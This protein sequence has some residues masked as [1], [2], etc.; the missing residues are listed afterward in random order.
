MT[1][2]IKNIVAGYL[3]LKNRR[4]FEEIRDYR[5]TTIEPEP[6]ARPELG[7]H[8]KHASEAAGGT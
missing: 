7:Q 6:Y 5:Q 2:A 1:E 8:D 4:A 3:T